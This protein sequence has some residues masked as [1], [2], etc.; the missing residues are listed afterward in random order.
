MLSSENLRVVRGAIYDAI[1]E[2]GTAPA[3]DALA[4]TAA[5]TVSLVEDADRASGSQ[6][7]SGGYDR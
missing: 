5:L 7:R 6:D 1:S 4:R 2:T 3:A